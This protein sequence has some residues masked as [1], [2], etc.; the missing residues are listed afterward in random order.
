MVHAGLGRDR[1]SRCG[2][3][4]VAGP[5]SVSWASSTFTSAAVR[6]LPANL[7]T[8]A[9]LSP[10]ILPALGRSQQRRDLLQAQPA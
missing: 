1:D 7:A 10:V 4:R 5:A 8:R 6:Y 9:R 2:I 3:F